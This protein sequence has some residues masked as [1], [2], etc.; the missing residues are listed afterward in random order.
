[1]IL[2]AGALMLANRYLFKAVEPVLLIDEP[3]QMVRA[4][5]SPALPPPQ[6]APCP[7][8]SQNVPALPTERK[9]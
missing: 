1:M 5:A 8:S 9:T 6:S 3:D 2:L 7:L 4:A